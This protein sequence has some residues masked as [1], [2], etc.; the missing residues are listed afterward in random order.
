MRNQGWTTDGELVKDDEFILDNDVVKI[1]D[2]INDIIREATAVEVIQYN[3]KPSKSAKEELADLK[4][5]IT[6][7]EQLASAK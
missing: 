1:H 5:R 3:R 2:H 4:S 7:L 6:D